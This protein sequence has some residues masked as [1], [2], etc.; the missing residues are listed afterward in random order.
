MPTA[1]GPRIFKCYPQCLE[2]LYFD[3]QVFVYRGKWSSKFSPKCSSESQPRITHALENAFSPLWSAALSFLSLLEDSEPGTSWCCHICVLSS[4]QLQEWKESDSIAFPFAKVTSE[5][6]PWWNEFPI[7]W[8]QVNH[9]A[10]FSSAQNE[11]SWCWWWL[12]RALTFVKLPPD[13][14]LLGSRSTLRNGITVL[15]ITSLYSFYPFY[16]T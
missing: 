14:C 11:P 16:N 5:L 6:I 1:S 10:G 12:P 3:I 8:L 4:V 15:H 13:V 9:K 2:S 7:V